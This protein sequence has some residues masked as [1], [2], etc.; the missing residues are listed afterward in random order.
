MP[1]CKYTDFKRKFSQLLKL[2]EFKKTFPITY[3]S[4]IHTAQGS[5]IDN[6]FIGESNLIESRYKKKMD[7]YSHLYT[8]LSRAKECIYIVE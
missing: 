2:L 8:A 1:I 6:I 3:I 5:T 7:L 4:S